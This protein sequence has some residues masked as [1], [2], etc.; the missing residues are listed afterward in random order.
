MRPYLLLPVL[1]SCAGAPRPQGSPLAPAA[2]YSVAGE[3]VEATSCPVGCPDMF[4]VGPPKEPID[5]LVAFR[6]LRGR[7]DGADLSG[8]TLAIAASSDRAGRWSGAIFLDGAADGAARDAAAKLV[9]GKFG[10]RFERLLPPRVVP[11]EWRSEGGRHLLRIGAEASIGS[12][13][14][15]A[16][17]GEGGRPVTIE[18]APGALSPR[19]NLARSISDRLND[20]V[21]GKSWSYQGRHASFGAFEWRSP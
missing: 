6:I 4:G 8:R 18:N 21:L 5:A 14:I 19:V 7:V 1:A 17:P 2:A 20:P 10:S 12:L 15:D 9:A 13:E 16:V 11:M 3:Y